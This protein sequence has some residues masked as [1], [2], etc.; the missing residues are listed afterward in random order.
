MTS[1]FFAKEENEHDRKL[2]EVLQ[3]IEKAGMTLN[4]FKCKFKKRKLIFLG[5]KITEIQV[6]P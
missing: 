1:W 3:R 2:T 4:K 6:D 5:H